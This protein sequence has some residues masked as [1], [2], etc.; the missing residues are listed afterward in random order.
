MPVSLGRLGA[1]DP[2]CHGGGH[3]LAQ[4]RA[5]LGIEVRLNYFEF[6]QQRAAIFT[7]Q[8]V[9]SAIERGLVQRPDNRARRRK[10]FG[11]RMKHFFA[12]A[13]A[14]LDAVVTRLGPLDEGMSE[15]GVD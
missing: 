7:A 11:R 3:P 10:V 12:P 2:S 6:H 8:H 15:L 5:F 9:D 13:I 1:A 4:L 14:G